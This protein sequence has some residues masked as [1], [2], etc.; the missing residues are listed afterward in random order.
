MPATVPPRSVSEAV[1]RSGHGS[2]ISRALGELSLSATA[3]RSSVDLRPLA[4]GSGRFKIAMTLRA[5]KRRKSY[6]KTVKAKKGY[7]PR[8]SF[9]VG[10]GAHVT[11]DLTVRKRSGGRWVAFASGGA[12]LGA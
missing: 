9:H 2:V 6:T 12:E 8:V 4:V 5:D 3:S 7:T 1:L 10:G 11:V